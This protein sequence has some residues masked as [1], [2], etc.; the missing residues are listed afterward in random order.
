MGKEIK[1]DKPTSTNDLD[2]YKK[3]KEEMDRLGF[4]HMMNIMIT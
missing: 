3:V 1:N 2:D 4:N